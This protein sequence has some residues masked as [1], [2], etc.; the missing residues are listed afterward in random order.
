LGAWIDAA[1]LPVRARSS[2]DSTIW[3]ADFIWF[4]AAVGQPPDERLLWTYARQLQDE[5]SEERPPE[6]Q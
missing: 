3:F 6:L 4:C 1:Q 5:V 2:A